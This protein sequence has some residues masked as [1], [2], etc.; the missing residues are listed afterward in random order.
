MIRR[1]RNDPINT[2][3]VSRPPLH[4]R[5]EQTGIIAI[6]PRRCTSERSGAIWC[7]SIISAGFEEAGILRSSS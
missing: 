1:A 2:A 7:V 6:N 4:A 5:A 3:D